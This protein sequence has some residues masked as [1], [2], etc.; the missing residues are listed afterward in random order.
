MEKWI[1][2]VSGLMRCSWTDGCITVSGHE[3]FYLGCQRSSQCPEDQ[4]CVH[5]ECWR[6]SYVP[7]VPS[8]LSK[9]WLH[10]SETEAELS[11]TILYISF[12]FFANELPPDFTRCCDI[13]PMK[14]D[15]VTSAWSVNS[16]H[17]FSYESVGCGYLLPLLCQEDPARRSDQLNFEGRR[18]QLWGLFQEETT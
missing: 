9:F 12:L 4:H 1:V 11:A 18:M 5:R 6:S 14:Y 2:L 3:S 15:F 17:R 7:R 10:Q 16:K 13:S 8:Y